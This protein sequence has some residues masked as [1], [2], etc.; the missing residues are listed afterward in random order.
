MAERLDGKG[1]LESGWEERR[2]EDKTCEKFKSAPRLPCQ[3]K[4]LAHLALLEL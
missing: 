4:P 3:R 1:T 2:K